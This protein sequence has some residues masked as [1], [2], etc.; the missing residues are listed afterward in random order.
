MAEKIQHQVGKACWLEP[1]PDGHIVPVSCPPL[2]NSRFT[3]TFTFY[4]CLLHRTY[5]LFCLSHGTPPLTPESCTKH[6]GEHDSSKPTS[7]LHWCL[8]NVQQDEDPWDIGIWS[9][10]HVHWA[11]V[12]ATAIF[13]ALETEMLSIYYPENCRCFPENLTVVVREKYCTRHSQ[14]IFISRMATGRMLTLKFRKREH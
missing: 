1:G 6:S 12:G 2:I 4:V 3:A 10:V 8:H 14:G 11:R 9:S 7:G 13:N 5:T